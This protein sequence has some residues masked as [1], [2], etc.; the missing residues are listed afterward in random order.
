MRP[1]MG[2]SEY[3]RAGRILEIRLR[4]RSRP[5]QIA[6]EWQGG[7]T[8]AHSAADDQ[9]SRCPLLGRYRQRPN[10]QKAVLVFRVPRQS[11]CERAVSV[12]CAKSNPSPGNPGQRRLRA[13]FPLFFPHQTQS[14]GVTLPGHLQLPQKLPRKCPLVAN[15]SDRWRTSLS[16]QSSLLRRFF[17]CFAVRA[18]VPEHRKLVGP[19]TIELMRETPIFIGICSTRYSQLPRKLPRFFPAGSERDRTSE[20]MKTQ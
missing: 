10:R 15:F 12:R 18:N 3:Y 9:L 8:F 6:P 1:F 11:R 5:A 19:L 7:R 13:V 20:S 17:L 16:D 14:Y 2:T 4:L